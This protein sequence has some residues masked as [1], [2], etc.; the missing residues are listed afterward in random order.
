MCRRENLLTRGLQEQQTQWPHGRVTGDRK[1][2]RHAPH[3]QI[4][5]KTKRTMRTMMRGR[6][7]LKG[8]G[9]AVLEGGRPDP[10]EPKIPRPVR[11]L[12]R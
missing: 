6:G 3:W 8:R 5:V 12:Q 7:G 10:C 1:R 2:C 9:G 4:A 11:R